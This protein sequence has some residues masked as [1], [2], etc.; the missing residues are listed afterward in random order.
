M[1]TLSN[2]INVIKFGLK[3]GMMIFGKRR[4]LKIITEDG[5]IFCGDTVNST[6]CR[7]LYLNKRYEPS[8]MMY[9]KS[10]LKEGDIFIDVGANEGIFSILAGKLV[11]PEGKVYAIEPMPINVSLLKRNITENG[12]DNIIVLDV[13]AGEENKEVIFNDVKYGNMVGGCNNRIISMLSLIPGMVSSIKVKQRRLDTLIHDPLDKIKLIKI[14]AERYEPQILNGISTWL[15]P[16]C[17]TDFIIELKP[18]KSKEVIDL[19]LND[20]G[21]D[22]YMHRVD[23]MAFNDNIRWLK[24]NRKCTIQKNVLF[25]KK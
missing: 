15:N 13:A 8:I 1:T 18:K 25:T 20:Y 9:L 5:L 21:Y 14:D 4:D 19:F 24:L 23:S 6:L 7:L 17:S 10:T 3:Y 22:G 16:D 2:V 12:L 11:G